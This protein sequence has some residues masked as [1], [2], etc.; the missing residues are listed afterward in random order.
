MKAGRGRRI[1]LTA[2]E[3]HGTRV[4]KKLLDKASWFGKKKRD[5]EVAKQH[6]GSRSNVERKQA[7]RDHLKTRSV[8][9]VEQTPG[10][11]LARRVKEQLQNLEETLGFKLK[12]VE[13]SG[14]SLTSV[15]SQGQA[16]QGPQ[17]GRETC[18]TC[19]QDGEERPPCTLSSVVY[20]S[21]CKPCNPSYAKKGELER[22]EGSTPCLYVGETSR[23]IQEST[24]ELRGEEIPGATC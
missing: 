3:S 24:W 11:E 22:Q 12:V 21:I 8:M 18:V 1:H 6:H 16:S 14:R 5:E 4:R 10:G 17:C 7:R 2:E 9:F 15:F 20:E 13:R 23:T 19:N